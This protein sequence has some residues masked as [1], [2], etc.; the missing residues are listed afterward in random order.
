MNSINERIAKVVE[1]SELTKTAFASKLMVSQ[2]YVSNLC[3]GKN[4]P[5]DRTIADICREFDV[6]ETW[7]RT[8]EGEMF[9]QKSSDQ[10]ITAFIEE[11]MRN[12]EDNFKRRF[13]A[14]LSRLNEAEWKLL[15]KMVEEIVKG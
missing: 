6:S 9:V 2:Q 1:Y 3:L 14:M 11:I 7:L 10:Q 13:V 12:D 15:E 8:G 5:S 4:V